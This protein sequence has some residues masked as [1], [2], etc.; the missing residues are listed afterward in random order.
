MLW[1]E[2]GTEPRNGT[3]FNNFI[4]YRPKALS[5]QERMHYHPLCICSYAFLTRAHA[6]HTDYAFYTKSGFTWYYYYYYYYDFY[7]FEL[8]AN[9]KFRC[10]FVV[11]IYTEQKSKAIKKF[12][13]S[14][15]A[16]YHILIWLYILNIA[17]L[18][19]QIHMI[20]SL[21]FPELTSS[22]FPQPTA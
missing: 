22:S 11:S 14:I 13:D 4:Y 18:T 2:W 19:S 12:I 17:R 16:I 9:P 1:S 10:L 7:V 6:A 5:G 21:W 3:H 20:W 8:G 15:N